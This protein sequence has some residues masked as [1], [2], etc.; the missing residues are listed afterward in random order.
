VKMIMIRK[1]D[2][3]LRNWPTRMRGIIALI[4]SGSGTVV[5]VARLVET[6]GPLSRAAL[7]RTIDRHLVEVRH[8][9]AGCC[10]GAYAWELSHAR[11]LRAPVPYKH[12]AGAIIWV[13][14]APKVRAAIA[15]S[16]RVR[17]RAKAASAAR[18]KLRA[19]RAG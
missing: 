6:H 16:L 15:R 5:G 7:I 8:I 19:S 11:A 13:K 10:D 9:R 17:K 1:K 2:W 3:E 18:P 14:L 4:A 12:P